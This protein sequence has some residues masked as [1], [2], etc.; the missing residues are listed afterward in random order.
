M[1]SS[2]VCFSLIL[3]AGVLYASSVS[4]PELVYQVRSL[5]KLKANLCRAPTSW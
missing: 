3:V 2:A 1:K 4:A 5:L